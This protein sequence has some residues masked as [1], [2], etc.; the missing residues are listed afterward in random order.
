MMHRRRLVPVLALSALFLAG[1]GLLNAAVPP[2]N[3]PV[4]L[5]GAEVDMTNT[6]A[7]S[8]TAQQV[9]TSTEFGGRIDASDERTVADLGD[10]PQEPSSLETELLFAEVA[11]SSPA[12]VEGDFPESVDV[13]AIDVS[14]TIYNGDETAATSF[15]FDASASDLSVA[16]DRT[17]CSGTAPVSCTFEPND[18]SL[19]LVNLLIDGPDMD[20]LLDVLGNEPTL[21]T[22]EADISV[23]VEPGLPSDATFTATLG[24]SEGTLSF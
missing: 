20:A 8:V 13:T 14:L 15:T 23:T 17:G 5:D 22:V 16:F 6:D 3:D 11:V 7:A 19:V 18:A 1:C 4:G 9:G 10:L 24:T 12:A 21:N 2:V